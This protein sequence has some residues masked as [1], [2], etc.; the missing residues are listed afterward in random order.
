MST[1]QLMMKNPNL[2]V[3]PEQARRAFREADVILSK[4]QG[5]VE[6]LFSSGYN[7][8]YAFLVKCPRFETVFQKPRMTPMLVREQ[9]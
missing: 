5:N 2:K 3:L 8:Y 1:R 6:T 4:G 7:I 9:K